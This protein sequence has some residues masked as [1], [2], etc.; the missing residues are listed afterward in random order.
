MSKI[1]V[2][3]NTESLTSRE[4]IEDYYNKQDSMTN[5]VYCTIGFGLLIVLSVA[6]VVFGK[7]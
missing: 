6:T 3:K 7:F 5:C 2:I 1:R 4:T